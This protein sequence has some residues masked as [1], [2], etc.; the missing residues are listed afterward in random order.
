MDRPFVGF[1]KKYEYNYDKA[2]RKSTR[3]KIKLLIDDLLVKLFLK[4][5]QW[6]ENVD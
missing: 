5:K 6:M 1:N 4:D 3:E 2:F